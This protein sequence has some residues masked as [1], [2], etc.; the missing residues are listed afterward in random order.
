LLPFTPAPPLL[1]PPLQLHLLLLLLTL[2]LVLLLLLLQSSALKAA[3]VDKVVCVTV[4][5]PAEVQRWAAQHGFDKAA[6]VRQGCIWVVVGGCVCVW[7]RGAGR[8]KLD[9]RVA[10]HESSGWHA[11]H[12]Y[13]K[14][15]L[16]RPEG[17]VM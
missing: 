1:P 12:G 4:G 9:Q 2:Q 13:A 5:E 7:G 16:V 8:G 14:A 15:P 17:A 11:H 3:G 10:L 6:L